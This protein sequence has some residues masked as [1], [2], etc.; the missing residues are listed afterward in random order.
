MEPD[1]LA[2]LAEPEA[3]AELVVQEESVPLVL[4]VRP[5]QPASLASRV[6]LA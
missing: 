4:L 2:L 1:L 3:R 6:Q 5:D